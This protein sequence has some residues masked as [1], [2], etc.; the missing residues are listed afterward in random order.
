L[1]LHFTG[2]LLQFETGWIHYREARSWLEPAIERARTLI[3]ENATEVSMTDFIRALRSMGWL[4]VTHGDMITGHSFLDESIQLA[5]EF[6]EFHSLTFAL[7]MK[8]QA[9]GS[10]VTWEII[11]QLEEVIELCRREGYEMELIMALFSVGQAYLVKGDSEKGPRAIAEVIDLVEKYDVLYIK[12]WV[13]YVQAIKARLTQEISEA[14]RYYLL[15]VHANEKLGN[16]RLVATGRSDLA[17]L[18]RQEGRLDEAKAIYRQTILSWQEQGHQAAVAHQLECFAY[19]ALIRG[20]FA[21]AAQLLGAAQIARQ[22]INS[23]STEQVEIAEKEQAMKKLEVEIGK[24]E[25][26]RLL[27]KGELMSLDEAVA[28]ALEDDRGQAGSFNANIAHEDVN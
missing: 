27:T 5:R 16:Q 10:N 21:Y 25:L 9:M 6:E 15:A 19:I 13:Y 14:E 1:T 7:G 4:L 20:K 17:H 8:A 12:S 22:R 24:N 3:E 2:V 23:P 18:Y 11:D 26:D 28:F